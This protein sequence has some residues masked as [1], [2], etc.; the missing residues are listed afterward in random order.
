MSVHLNAPTIHELW[1]S[2]ANEIF[3][4]GE[5]SYPRGMGCTELLGVT[6]RLHDARQNIL[7]HKHRKLNYRFMVAEWLWIWFG[8]DDVKTIA[9]YNPNIAQFSDNGVDFNGSYGVPVREQWR[10]LVE[11]LRTDPDT[12][13][14][15]LVIY[16]VPPGPTKDVP[17]TISLQFIKRL[18]VL[19]TIA[20]MRSSD[21]WL[22]LPYDTFNFSMLANCMSAELGCEL[23][24]L[25]LQL[26]SSHLYDR[27]RE[28]ALSLVNEQHL[29]ET[30]ASRRFKEVP[31]DW[32]DEELQKPKWPRGT[33]STSVW[34]RYKEVLAGGALSKA[35]EQLRYL[36]SRAWDETY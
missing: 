34:V 29:F 2:L 6:L 21:L 25:T 26:G 19:H 33:G 7:Y 22:G 23:G 18:G 35:S 20:T 8:H 24:S 12:R 5:H 31:P 16:R 14:G 30:I 9:R 28:N 11:L 1:S 17:C 3:L 13:Q 27:N 4:K 32:L 10:R 15:V 36:G